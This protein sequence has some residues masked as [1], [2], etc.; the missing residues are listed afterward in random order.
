MTA[1]TGSALRVTILSVFPA[2]LRAPL[3]EGVL[4]RAQADGLV[5]IDVRDLRVHAT[6]RHRSLDDTPYGAGAGMLLLA[7]PVLAALDAAAPP[8][9][10]VRVLLA[11]DG[12]PFDQAMARSLAQAGH[13]VLLAA[14]YEGV[15]ERVRDHVDRVVS[16]GDF[17]L[18]G[19]EAAAWAI[20]EAVARLVPAVVQ[21]RS[22]HEESF[23]DRLLEAPQYT[24]PP[25]LTWNGM[26]SAV[27]EVVRSGH[28]GR[29]RTARR[30]A[31]LAR[32]LIRRPDLLIGWR[33]AAG[34]S[35]LL[36]EVLVAAATWARDGTDWAFRMLY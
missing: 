25:A 20:V 7:Q 1:R 16:L 14:R 4:G 29:E 21:A 34:D 11:P 30:R 24:R 26:H 2:W 32:T 15:D 33:P 19:G 18:M 27:P 6:D 9:E 3:E 17:V 8:G 36:G 22:L 28:H 12:E 13:V 5:R 35:T 31:A 10:A 23:D